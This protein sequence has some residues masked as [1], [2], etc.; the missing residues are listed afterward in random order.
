[1]IKLGMV[2][3][4][5]IHN[6]PYAAW[7]NGADAEALEERCTKAW[8][9]ELIRGR[10][11]EPVAQ[12]SR[13]THVWA[14]V[15]E[16]AE[17]IAAS[18]RI[19]NVCDSAEEVLENVDGLLVLDEEF[20]PRT[21]MVE[22]CLRAGKPV[23]V[24]KV[25]A[26]DPDKTRELVDLAQEKDVP[27]AAWSQLLFA[28]EAVSLQG[29]EGGVALVTFSLAKDIVAQYGI[30]LV[31]SAFAA[32]GADPTHMAAIDGGPDGTP[33][34]ELG[35][36]D[37]KDVVLRAGTDVPA[38]GTVAYVSKQGEPTVARL[39]DMGAMFDGSAA[40]LTAMFEKGIWPA[41]PEALV[42]MS[43]AAALLTVRAA[44]R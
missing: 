10:F 41:P 43:E 16:E 35:Y 37:G 2:G 21:R 25:A 30:H 32:F 19:E 24:D 8:M 14:G 13:I 31:C 12:G 18:C 36:A 34:V 15:H 7:F 6:Y 23:F 33:M 17:A 42:R 38:R 22:A 28:A 27:M 4:T 11:D 1:M 9:L 39:M 29:C 3:E 44:H 26:L 5:L 40:A 20:E